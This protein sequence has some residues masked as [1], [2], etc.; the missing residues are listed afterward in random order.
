[1]ELANEWRDQDTD[2]IYSYDEREIDIVLDP[3]SMVEVERI[4]YKNSSIISEDVWCEKTQGI[5]LEID[6][7][8]IRTWRKGGQF[9]RED[10]PA[11]VGEG[12]KAWYQNGRQHRDPKEGPS[13]E[14]PSITQWKVNG[15]LH[16]LD[17]PAHIEDNNEYFYLN[18]E[19]HR[20]DGPAIIYPN[21]TSKWAYAGHIF[22]SEKDWRA[23]KVERASRH[24]REC[25][26]T[27]VRNAYGQLSSVTGPSLFD[28]SFAEWNLLGQRHRLGGPAYTEVS[29]GLLE[30]SW[31][32]NGK[33]HRDGDMPAKSIIIDNYSI[34]EWHVDGELHRS[35]G[36]A[37]MEIS[38]FDNSQYLKQWYSNGDLH[39]TDGPAVINTF[40]GLEAEEYWVLGE[41]FTQE[42]F[43]SGSVLI[44]SDEYHMHIQTQVDELRLHKEHGP[45][46]ISDEGLAKH[47]ID[48]QLHR[49]DG[50]AI[51]WPDGN[52][53]FYLRGIKIDQASY[54]EEVKDLLICPRAKAEVAIRPDNNAD[55][56]WASVLSVTVAVSII[57]SLFKNKNKEKEKAIKANRVAEVAN[58]R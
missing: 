53:E 24:V 50:P 3:N 41:A 46:V 36:P 4:Y 57:S 48:G 44:E 39:R 21:G 11:L 42:Q 54:W 52:Q 28:N 58:R 5:S 23:Y 43:E 26:I 22:E 10:G 35:K 7:A 31:Y 16:R 34:E 8:G 27:E 38:V 40:P 9:H 6:D 1:M 20:E 2:D 19:L 18:G 13:Y 12:F 25:G 47:Y 29:D 33:L 45:A 56:S 17:G 37:S 30:Q 32:K 14:S 55:S 15:L 51:I 49:E